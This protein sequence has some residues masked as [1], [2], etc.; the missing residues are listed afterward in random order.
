ML[1]LTTKRPRTLAKGPAYQ[2][3]LELL[4]TFDLSGVSFELLDVPICPKK[5]ALQ[6]TGFRTGKPDVKRCRQ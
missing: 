3:N 2:A 5:S 6:E 1:E 4:R